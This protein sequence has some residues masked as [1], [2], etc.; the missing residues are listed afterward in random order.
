MDVFC[1]GA[2]GTCAQGVGTRN[3]TCFVGW[4]V[5]GIGLP[6]HQNLFQATHQNLTCFNGW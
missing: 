4:Y 1:M 6:G 3:F 2:H 5:L